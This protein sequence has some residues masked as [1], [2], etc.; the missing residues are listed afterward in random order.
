VDEQV[1]R[2]SFYS[3][4]FINVV[5]VISLSSN[6]L[7]ISY[8]QTFHLW[9]IPH[10]MSCSE[11]SI[12]LLILFTTTK[13]QNHWMVSGYWNYRYLIDKSKRK[14]KCSSKLTHLLDELLS[15]DARP[16]DLLVILDDLTT[17]NMDP[18]HDIFCGIS[19]KRNFCRL[20]F[21]FSMLIQTVHV[22]YSKIQMILLNFK[23]T[24]VFFGQLDPVV[25]K[26]VT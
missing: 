13:E 18:W 25:G 15:Y 6:H 10:K 20:S 9:K 12:Q 3:F 11:W 16:K 14:K 17:A 21:M 1:L 24:S 2:S 19:H 22:Y 26:I 5:S 23:F 7:V 8:L 4:A